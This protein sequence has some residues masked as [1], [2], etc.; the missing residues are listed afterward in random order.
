M[1]APTK[2]LRILSGMRPT[3][4]LHIGHL[5]G[6][7][8][9]WVRLQNEGHENFHMVADW[10]ALT[11]DYAETG[12][13]RDHTVEMVID[14]LAVGLD[15]EKSVLFRQSRVPQHAE[16]YLLLN[17]VTP[18]GWLERNP[19]YKEQLEELRTHGKD[20]RMAGFFTY[21]VLQTADIV[22]YKATAVPVGADQAAHVEL[23]R[24]IV[25]RFNNFYGAIFPEPQA[26]HTE[27]KAIPGLDGRKMSKS[28]GNAI[29]LR[30]TAAETTAK[31]KPM[32][33][34]PARKRRTDPGEPAKCPVFDLHK[35]YS[36]EA[37][38]EWVS[39]GCRTAEIGCIDCKTKLAERMNGALAP[40]R[41]RRAQVSADPAQV[42]AILE[43]GET[44]ARAVAEATMQE[45]REAIQ[46]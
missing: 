22:I 23:A 13:L 42:T 10:H 14:W 17:M 41:E 46:I 9:N 38:L 1:S 12:D 2:P 25:R 7:L 4:H 27:A 28:Y 15:P 40:L 39:H 11:S 44:Q 18:L 36:T 43:A 6:A 33:T 5:A 3:G 16:L 8:D 30:D 35:V 34:D 31:L 37:D 32:L 26:L 19:T 20:V 29:L 45:V 24:E 21:P